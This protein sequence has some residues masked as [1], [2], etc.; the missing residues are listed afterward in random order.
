M[1]KPLVITHAWM[2]ESY[3]DHIAIRDMNAFGRIVERVT[4]RDVHVITPI[5]CAGFRARRDMHDECF[6]MIVFWSSRQPNAAVKSAMNVADHVYAVVQ[7]PNWSVNIQHDGPLTLV[8]PFRALE[9][10]DIAD[11]VSE[12]SSADINAPG[13]QKHVFI[14]FGE[15]AFS[16]R[17]YMREFVTSPAIPMKQMPRESERARAAYA[18]SLKPER[19]E[20]MAML[21]ATGECD[22]YGRFTAR[23]LEAYRGKQFGESDEL[24]H[25]VHGH[26]RPMSV[27]RA[28][29]A[30]EAA[31]LISDPMMV[32]FQT[33]YMRP[34]EYAL[35]GVPVEV[36]AT[37]NEAAKYDENMLGEFVLDDTS[38]RASLSKLRDAYTMGIEDRI[39]EVWG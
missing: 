5:E 20:L 38:G 26:L 27:W 37:T 16:D 35:A 18:G 21:G 9:D 3:G 4:G 11:V 8:T 33:H 12:L 31:V 14:P 29:A 23:D 13:A 32:R 39:R 22:L 36:K 6:E 34:L 2:D 24:R 1:N 28:Y 30:H 25:R 15:M 17:R 10:K 7:D 19:A